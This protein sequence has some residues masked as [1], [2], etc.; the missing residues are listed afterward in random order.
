MR[1]TLFGLSYNVAQLCFGASSPLIEN[2]IVDALQKA[3]AS[4]WSAHASPAF[5]C[6]AAATL[7]LVALGVYRQRV[8][9]GLM[10]ATT[11][12]REVM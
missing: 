2:A 7:A 3:G 12:G 1:A 6:I 4:R 5:W 8:R 10:A 9:L 11:T